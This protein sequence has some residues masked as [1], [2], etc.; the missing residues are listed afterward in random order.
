MDSASR[1]RQRVL[2]IRQRRD[3]KKHEAKQVLD[4]VKKSQTAIETSAESLSTNSFG[5]DMSAQTLNAINPIRSDI[6]SIY[7]SSSVE[8]AKTA[9]QDI[10]NA[11]T[12][13]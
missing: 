5:A 3:A 10:K 11:I 4:Y 6:K 7:Q 8:P 13:L 9:L 12:Q 2:D 1:L